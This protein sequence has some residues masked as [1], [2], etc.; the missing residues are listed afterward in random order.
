LGLDKTAFALINT[1]R[2]GK[3][4]Q[5]FYSPGFHGEK[6]F[7]SRPGTFWVTAMIYEPSV[8]HLDLCTLAYHL[9]SQSL[10]WGR[11]DP[12]YEE[13]KTD[14]RRARF[15]KIVDKKFD[16]R[17]SQPKYHGSGRWC[18]WPTNDDLDPI[19]NDYL[20]ICPWRPAFTRAASAKDGWVLYNTPED[21][22]RHILTVKV[23]AYRPQYD[24]QTTKRQLDELTPTN[25]TPPPK[26]TG[27]TDLLYGFEG[28]TGYT[29][30]S[31]SLMGFVLAR[32][33]SAREQN[34]LIF[35]RAD[36][37]QPGDP[38]DVHIVFRGSRSGFLR[39]LDAKRR[40]GNPDW[41]T[42]LLL[43]DPR[44]EPVICNLQHAQV[45]K[46]FAEA[47]ITAMPPLVEALDKI[48]QLKKPAKPRKIWVAG[49]SLGG[50]LAC[51]FS[52][53]ILM[54]ST[55]N[56][57]PKNGT[58]G[59]S[60]DVRTWDWGRLNLYT[61]SAP[62]VG[63]E[64]F[65]QAIKNKIAGNG[66]R[67]YIVGDPITREVGRQ[68]HAEWVDIELGGKGGVRL[69]YHQPQKVR[70][71]LIEYE[72]NFYDKPQ[73]IPASGQPQ[74]PWQVH[75]RLNALLDVLS[76]LQS[77]KE[78]LSGFFDDFQ[79]YLD[80]LYETMKF[81]F[82]HGQMVENTEPRRIN[83]ADSIKRL[84]TALNAVPKVN[85]KTDSEAIRT[86]W[87]TDCIAVAHLEPSLWLFLGV[88]IVLAC[89]DKLDFRD[90]DLVSKLDQCVEVK[91]EKSASKQLGDLKHLF[92]ELHPVSLDLAV[93]F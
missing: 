15:M 54:G 78:C 24:P 85:P 88:C 18:Y 41:V 89:Q 68:R 21:I 72:N 1:Y 69:D 51:H 19:V 26:F 30:P 93:L 86:V 9:H 81:S 74:L 62:M 90:G 87:G 17:G 65:H 64:S 46:G 32:S 52:S 28:G 67:Y 35:D 43:T 36:N 14:G 71:Y 48:A 12:Y 7:K 77:T 82:E 92:P 2:T 3:S 27:G 73:Y 23:I 76:K 11:M 45:S 33:V 29:L 40:E 50:A 49:H 79:L 4:N 47:V 63:N 80:I 25:S 57:L 59:L 16:Y 56:H 38:Y 13:M 66:R 37:A 60:S 22:V 55:Y 6:R 44:R 10:L 91:G 31:W 61:F 53:A 70:E 20:R 75:P 5:W 34:G 42:D 58:G 8:F 84:K 39:P 83:A